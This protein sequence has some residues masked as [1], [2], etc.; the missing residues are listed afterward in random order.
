MPTPRDTP[1]AITG[2]KNMPC[3]SR[4][5]E[6]GIQIPYYAM[7]GRCYQEKLALVRYEIGPRPRIA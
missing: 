7:I 3:I 2:A 4:L 1:S 5:R 6:V